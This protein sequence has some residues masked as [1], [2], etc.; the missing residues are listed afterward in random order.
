VLDGLRESD[1]GIRVPKSWFVIDDV[2]N[3]NGAV[4]GDTLMLSTGTLMDVSLEAVVA[5]ELG[6]LTAIDARLTVAL[7]RLALPANL[8]VRRDEALGEG[9]LITVIVLAGW[10]ISGELAL[11]LK[12]SSDCPRVGHARHRARRAG[13]MLCGVRHESA[14]R[15]V[16]TDELLPDPQH[17]CL[18]SRRTERPIMFPGRTI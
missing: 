11:N 4:L 1:P 10:I 5:H 16:P 6:H 17:D 12:R 18:T 13:P 8:F 15:R 2:R 3:T 9:C 7:N 14:P